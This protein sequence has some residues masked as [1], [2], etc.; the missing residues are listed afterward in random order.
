MTT[1]RATSPAA[2]PGAPPTSMSMRPATST[3]TGARPAAWAA[4]AAHT[5]VTT[6][7]M[8]VCWI[9]RWFLYDQ[10]PPFRLR[11]P[12]HFVA[13]NLMIFPDETLSGWWVWQ[14]GRIWRAIVGEVFFQQLLI[15][16]NPISE[17]IP[18]CQRAVFVWILPPTSLVQSC[19]WWLNFLFFFLSF[20]ICRTSPS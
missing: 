6:R 15:Q 14:H 7:K 12:G 18:C 11:C 16:G 2:T 8:Y 19:L 4:A 20:V 5:V 3:T 1:T 9:I 17:K 13:L 10:F